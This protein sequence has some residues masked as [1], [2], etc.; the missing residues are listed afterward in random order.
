MVSEHCQHSRA[1]EVPPSTDA[2]SAEIL[3]DL[4]GTMLFF[5]SSTHRPHADNNLISS[6]KDFSFCE[7]RI[8]AAVHSNRPSPRR[9]A[10]NSQIRYRSKKEGGI[11]PHV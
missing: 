4:A 2:I 7:G 9:R 11:E 3:P 6:S 8:T 1:Q 5:P 10:P